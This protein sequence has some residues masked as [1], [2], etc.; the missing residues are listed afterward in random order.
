VQWPVVMMSWSVS[1]ARETRLPFTKVPLLLPR[2]MISW[3]PA[4][5]FRDSAWLRVTPGSSARTRSLP[6]VGLAGDSDVVV[7]SR[8]CLLDGGPAETAVSYI[9]ADLAKGTP[10]ADP[11]PG[12]G[13]IYAR[14]EE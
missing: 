7:R 8:R 4:G 10:I 5:D 3:F 14:L 12:P 11:N 2:S 6:W 9:P 13:G 1:V